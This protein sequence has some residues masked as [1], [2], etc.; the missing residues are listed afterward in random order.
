MGRTH[1][2]LSI[3]LLEICL[4]IPLDFFQTTFWQLKEDVLLCIVGL[5]ILVGGA[6]LPDLDNHVSKAGATLGF[7]GSIFTIFMQST[8]SIV[9][10]IYHGKRDMPP[11]SQHRYLWHTLLVAVGFICLF[12]FGMPTGN[13]T[14]STNITNS[15]QTGQFLYFLRT[16]AVLVLFLLLSFVA[17][18]T[19]SS[20][21]LTSIQKIYPLPKMVKYIFPSLVLIYVFTTNYTNLRIL[22]LCMS[23]GYLFHLLEDFFADSGIPALFPIPIG[24]KVWK[25]FSFPITVTTGGT[26][27]TMIDYI[28]I[29]FVFLLFFILLAKPA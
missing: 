21:I 11:L 23:F 13:F 27:N 15:I 1:A 24:K 25:R 28:G 9:Y 3:L 14:I 10:S 12:Y 18:L 6:L 26:V 7:I 20:M 22:S 19:G 2:I 5:C 29:C 4:L 8:S 17:T 16:N